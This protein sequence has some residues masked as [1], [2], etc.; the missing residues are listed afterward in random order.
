MHIRKGT[1]DDIKWISSLLTDGVND[2]HYSPSMKCQTMDFLQSVIENGGVNLMK[3]RGVIQKPAFIKME[4]T[5]A[6]LDGVPASFLICAKENN[7]VEIH[8]A[9]TVKRFR[10]NGC[11]TRLVSDAITKY[12]NY[13]VYARCYKKS[14]WAVE[15]LKKLDFKPTKTGNPIELTL[16]K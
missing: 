15:G 14:S 1:I 7:E 11:F 3:L 9:G 13:H 2:G 12:S 8:L 4:L 6:E 16:S 5:V 10:K